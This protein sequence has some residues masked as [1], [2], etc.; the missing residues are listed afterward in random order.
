MKV[1]ELREI[2]DKFQ[3]DD[4]VL[5]PNE[6]ASDYADAAVVLDPWVSG[7]RHG[8]KLVPAQAK[9]VQGDPRG[10]YA[11]HAQNYLKSPRNVLK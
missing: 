11:E 3:D 1:R 2:L 5:I 6:Y 7:M 10:F 8:L 4:D 9:A